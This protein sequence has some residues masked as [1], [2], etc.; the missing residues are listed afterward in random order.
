V[1]LALA[2]D[3][4]GR[5]LVAEA[6]GQAVGV[7]ALRAC[8]YFERPGRFCR[9]VALVVR[10]DR[11]EQGVGR[12]LV[13]AAE[14]IALELGCTEMEVTSRRTRED[15]EAFYTALGYE[16]ACEGSARFKRRI[17]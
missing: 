14:S 15:A 3:P 8:P 7:L 2:G 1:T 17:G 16:D 9:I 4:S 11:R 10:G 5:V 6:E 13:E 12:R